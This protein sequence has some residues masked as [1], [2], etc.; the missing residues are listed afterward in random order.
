MESL[1]RTTSKLPK[2]WPARLSDSFHNRLN[3][4]ALAATAAGVGVLGLP[5]PAEAEIVFTRAHLSLIGYVS[6]DL[7]HDGISDFSFWL[8]GGC[9]SS[10][11]SSLQYVYS[12]PQP[13]AVVGNGHAAALRLGEEIGPNRKFTRARRLVL[14]QVVEHFH[15]GPGT[16][17][18]RWYGPWANGGKGF[19]TRYLGL[20]FVINGTFH[21]GW[22]RLNSKNGLPLILTGYAYETIPNKA[23]IAGA[24]KGSGCVTGQPGTL[25]SLGELALG[26]K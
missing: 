12:A 17:S 2:L 9:D 5:S 19:C 23:I 14:E 16:T 1:G 26:R 21:Y 13:N 24:T 3:M 6:L 8:A 25:G 10:R 18:F 7:N 11:C 15:T 4:Y 20:K 22:A